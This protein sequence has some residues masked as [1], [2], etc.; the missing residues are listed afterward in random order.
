MFDPCA[1]DM[2]NPEDEQRSALLVMHSF[3]GVHIKIA[4]DLG[5]MTFMRVLKQAAST[6]SPQM[7]DGLRLWS[8]LPYKIEIIYVVKPPERMF[9]FIFSTVVARVLS[10][11]MRGRVCVCDSMEEVFR[12]E[13]ESSVCPSNHT[14]HSV[15]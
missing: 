5:S 7:I 10:Q 14:S 1:I 8:T 6:T 4:I 12:M 13:E 2:D 11:K 15:Q 3:D 9:D